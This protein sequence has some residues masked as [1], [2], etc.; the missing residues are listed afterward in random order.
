MAIVRLQDA[1]FDVDRTYREVESEILERFDD[2]DVDPEMDSLIGVRDDGS[3]VASIW[4]YVPDSAETLWRAFADVH[5]LP[6][7]RSELDEFTV[8]WW[9]ARSR[10]RLAERS[11][12]LPKV[13]WFGVYEHRVGQVALLQGKGYEIR[14]YYDELIRDLAEPI[15]DRAPPQGIEL[16]PADEARPGD[17]LWVHNEAFRDHWGSQPFTEERWRQFHNEFYLPAASFVAYDDREPVG[18]VFSTKYPHDFADRGFAHSWV[19]SLGV[20]P[21]HR[22][23][24]VAT[25]LLAVALRA[26]ADDGMEYAVLDVDSENPTGAYGLYEG[27]GFVLDRRSLAMLKDV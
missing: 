26:F 6:E 27:L 18:H 22:K 11:D 7:L 3:V 12:D 8:D 4:S 23:R 2:V 9:E 21:S 5:V 24:G 16:V 1:C 13:L 14:R 20:I 19:E 15:P 17:E 10:Q 25:A